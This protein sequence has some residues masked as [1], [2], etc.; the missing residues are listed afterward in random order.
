ML[1]ILDSLISR[2]QSAFLP[3]RSISEMFCWLKN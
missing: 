3:G 1:P 2:N